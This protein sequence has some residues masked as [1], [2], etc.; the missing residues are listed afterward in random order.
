[1]LKKIFVPIV[2][3]LLLLTIFVSIILSCRNDSMIKELP[4]VNFNTQVLPIFQSNC[5]ISGC[6]NG[7]KGRVRLNL[8]DYNYIVKNVVPGKPYSSKIYTVLIDVYGQSMP[9][10][11][12]LSEQ[13]RMLI[14]VWIE[15][16]AKNT[17]DTIQNTLK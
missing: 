3:I 12:P 17:S 5:A 11:R 16:G 6:H 13:D 14:K 4:Q 9:P 2:I 1:M 15:Q 10:A 8:T 7:Q